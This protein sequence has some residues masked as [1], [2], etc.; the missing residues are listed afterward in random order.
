MVESKIEIARHRADQQT[1]AVQHGHRLVFALYPLRFLLGCFCSQNPKI[2]RKSS[3]MTTC[4]LW[5]DDGDVRQ[6]RDAKSNRNRI[7]SGRGGRW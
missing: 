6:R 4:G 3:Q 1:N 7:E 2:V 5:V